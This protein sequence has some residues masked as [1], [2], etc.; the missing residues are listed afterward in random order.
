MLTREVA[1]LGWAQVRNTS[2]VQPPPT[3]VIG[4]LS[5]MGL[6]NSLVGGLIVAIGS[7]LPHVET[8]GTEYIDKVTL[9]SGLVITSQSIGV[10]SSSEGFEGTDGIIG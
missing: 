7:S 3:P 10:A 8:V 4:S 6:E 5:A 2:P 1:T 9:T